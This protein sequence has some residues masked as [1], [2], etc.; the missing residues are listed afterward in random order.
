MK[1]GQNATSMIWDLAE[2][3]FARDKSVRRSDIINACLKKGLAPA[4]VITQISSWVTARKVFTARGFKPG[5][6]GAAEAPKL[7]AKKRSKP[8]KAAKPAP[9]DNAA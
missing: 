7:T 5:C 2:T 4:T 9:Q 1:N 8:A 6:V 3:M